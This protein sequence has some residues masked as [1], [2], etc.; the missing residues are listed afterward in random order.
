M[1]VALIDVNCKHSSTGKI[2]Y[3]LYT[4][5]NNN[6]NEAAVYYGRGPK[7][8]EK[9]IF[10]FSI[11]IETYFHALMTRI[12][13]LTGFYSPFSTWR[14]IRKLK[15]FNPDIVHIHELHA[16][17]I[18][19]GTIIKFLK[20]K[21][22]KTVMTHYSEFMYTGK[23]AHSLDCD[24]FQ[25]I[26]YSCPQVKEYPKSLFFDFTK[27]MFKLKKKWLIDFDFFNVVPSQWS[28]E[29]LKLSFLKDKPTQ[30]IFNGLN[31][32]TLFK[33]RRSDFLVKKYNL[34]SKFIILAV[35]PDLMS[36]FKGGRWV[37][38]I[39]NRLKDSNIVF[40]LIGVK[41]TSIK[42]PDNVIVLNRTNNQEELIDYYSNADLT[43]LTSKKE[44]FSMVTAESISC[45]TPVV[46]FDSGAPSQIAPSPYGLFTEYGLLDRV[47]DNIL[48]IKSGEIELAD[49]D[50]CR[51]Y[52]IENFSI[53]SMANNYTKLYKNL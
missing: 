24:K 16:Y 32:M 19:I 9:N 51:K 34:E 45:G 30:V 5:L 15:K 35:A 43:L 10:K 6:G 40:I 31:T 37:L 12:T 23:C 11:D 33:P 21:K 7:I 39:A 18:N 13:G 44:T 4:E 1:K 20:N 36:E 41:D 8:K 50:M 28:S 26:C 38:K 48:K 27:K 53:E 3:D 52:A 46:G 29:R 42:I 49:K 2:V 22:I 17:F 25:T 14:L 47:I